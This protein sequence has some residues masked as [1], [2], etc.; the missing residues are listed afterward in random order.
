MSIKCVRSHFL[1]CCTY[2]I[3]L[4]SILLRVVYFLAGLELDLR[5]K[6][7]YYSKSKEIV[8]ERPK[9]FVFRWPILPQKFSGITNENLKKEIDVNT[10]IYII[11]KYIF[12]LTKKD[13]FKFSK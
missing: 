7:Q 13:N 9:G 4:S 10:S 5:V 11:V 1:N 3:I 6:G 12:S 8:A 2:Y